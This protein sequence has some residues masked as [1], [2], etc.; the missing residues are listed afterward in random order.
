MLK[1]IF[2]GSKRAL[3]ETRFADST[4]C[5]WNASRAGLMDLSILR[6]DGVCL[7]GGFS[8]RTFSFGNATLLAKSWVGHSISRGPF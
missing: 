8:N 7:Y 4:H 2:R 6:G 3:R 1:R 5:Y